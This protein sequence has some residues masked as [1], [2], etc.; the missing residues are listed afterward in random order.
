M[1]AVWGLS[2]QSGKL[3]GCRESQPRGLADRGSETCL[4]PSQQPPHLRGHENADAQAPVSDRLK[5][6]L[7]FNKVAG[8]HVCV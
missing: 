1:G 7:H 6:A 5:D 8:V 2:G 3:A 4:L